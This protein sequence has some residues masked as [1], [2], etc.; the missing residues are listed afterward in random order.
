M[1][2]AGPADAG[3]PARDDPGAA[4]PG[5]AGDRQSAA[6]GGLVVGDDVD[7]EVGAGLA[8]DGRADAGAEDV[9]PGL[10]AAGA[11]HDL[12]GVDAARELQQRGRDVVAD[13]VVEGAA[14]V[15]DEGA[16]DG[17]LLGRGGGQPVAAGDVDGEDLAA[18]AL[19][20]HPGGA[21]DE[22][23]ALG[24]AGEAD[25]DALA[26]LPGGAD[27]VLAA[28]LLEVLVDPVGDPEQGQLA[29]RGEVAGAE[30]VGQGRVD[31]VRLC[32]CCRAPSGG[33]APAA[34]CRPA[35]SGRPGG[36]PRRGRSPA[37][38]RR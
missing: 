1:S 15:L 9:L 10:A 17:Q 34:T 26:G 37:A 5:A 32:R 2:R 8:G 23:A 30:V 14:E 6:L 22:R 25:D 3:Q 4:E 11:E 24:A 38:V 31:L 35:R 29:Q 12:G 28:V 20:G 33:A 19:G 13:D 7:V 16:L 36:R 27:V 21:A 18:G